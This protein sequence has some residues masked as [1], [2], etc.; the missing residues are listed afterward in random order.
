[1]YNCIPARASD[2]NDWWSIIIAWMMDDLST[3]PLGSGEEGSGI[4]VN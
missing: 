2:K 1:M 3:S 4:Q